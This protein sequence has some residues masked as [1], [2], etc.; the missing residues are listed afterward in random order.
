MVDKVWEFHPQ[1]LANTARAFATLP[2]KDSELRQVVRLAAA[3]KV[4]EF[5][6]QGLANSVWASATLALEDSE[7]SGPGAVGGLETGGHEV[8]GR[9]SQ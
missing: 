3:C 5:N 4:G 2:A 1:N 8:R 7:L 6:P 9:H